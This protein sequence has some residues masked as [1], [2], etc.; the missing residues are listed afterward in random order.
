MKRARSID[1]TDLHGVVVMPS[2][3]N[4][5]TVPFLQTSFISVRIAFLVSALTVLHTYSNGGFVRLRVYI[6]TF[7]CLYV[8]VCVS[9][10]VRLR[11]Y[12]CTFA[13]LYVY[14][15]VSICVS[16]KKNVKAVW[17]R[18]ATYC[19][20]DSMMVLWTVSH[21]I[22]SV[23]MMSTSW[24]AVNV[25]LCN[26]AVIE[27]LVR[28]LPTLFQ[29]PRACVISIRPETSGRYATV[30]PFTSITQFLTYACVRS[31][32]SM[33]SL[34]T[35]TSS[36]AVCRDASS[37]C[38]DTRMLTPN[39]RLQHLELSIV[40]GQREN[41]VP[42]I[43]RLLPS[44]T[45]LELHDESVSLWDGVRLQI[46]LDGLHHLRHLSITGNP[47]ERGPFDPALDR[48][49]VRVPGHLQ[50]LILS[51]WS[52]LYT[53]PLAYQSNSRYTFLWDD[54]T[55]LQTLHIDTPT[56]FAAGSCVS[57]LRS[58]RHLSVCGPALHS[59][60]H[61]YECLR[62]TSLTQLS[63]G[64]VMTQTALPPFAQPNL[65]R[66]DLVYSK[67]YSHINIFQTTCAHT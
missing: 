42:D 4:L 37:G 66:L 54:A 2:R 6:C 21:F 32:Q 52:R 34:P 7:A 59:D 46:L 12:M 40:F 35:S 19:N 31:D 22:R 33:A 25:R 11:V 38:V 13:C 8:Y 61:L 15:C 20:L 63:L 9:I 29:W 50:T 5:P 45:S 57:N 28:A 60:E 24:P 18:I 10:C 39:I 3:P 51:P 58:L 55:Q 56:V 26:R 14:V 27:M 41:V 49:Y 67:V 62:L 1:T 16:N 17:S 43:V 30:A 53:S 48:V 65:L 36:I 44:L 23:G 47:R 64:N